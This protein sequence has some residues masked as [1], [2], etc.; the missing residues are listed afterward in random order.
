MIRVGLG[1]DQ[2]QLT[3]GSRLVLGGVEL[4][5]TRGL[6]G[7][8]DA[9]V[10]TH[11]VIDAL[12]G[13]AA[14]GTIGEH[15]PDTD[16]RYRGTSSLT[17]LAA[18]AAMVHERGWRVGNVDSVIVAQEPRLAEHLRTMAR[19]LAEVLGVEEG[20]VSVKATSPEAVGALGRAEAIAAS[21]VALLERPA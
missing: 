13:A 8:S 19:R 12:L 18:T 1:Q 11:A 5:H 6:R 7:H 20:Q 21:A 3:P 10:L 9:D 4:G 16:E 17:L 14:L 15:F 2:H